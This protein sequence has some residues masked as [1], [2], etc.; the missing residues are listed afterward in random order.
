MSA[1]KSTRS[2]IY[3]INDYIKFDFR[4]NEIHLILITFDYDRR[5]VVILTILLSVSHFL[6][7][8]KMGKRLNLQFSKLSFFWR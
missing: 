3:V 8:W 2:V 5:N 7:N 1:K 6:K 4:V